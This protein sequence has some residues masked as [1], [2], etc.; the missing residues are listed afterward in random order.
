M[1]GLEGFALDEGSIVF[2]I[3]AASNVSS[4][5]LMLTQISGANASAR[6]FHVPKRPG[7]KRSQ[8][9]DI[10]LAFSGHRYLDNH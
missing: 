6:I 10:F 8:S 4:E 7:S 3:T 5:R 2:G 9:C 1:R